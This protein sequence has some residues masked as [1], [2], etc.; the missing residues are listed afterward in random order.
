MIGFEEDLAISGRCLQP[1]GGTGK[2]SMVTLV[3]PACDRMLGGNLGLGL[4]EKCTI[5]SE[6]SMTLVEE[7]WSDC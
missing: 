4:R 1:K 7:L 5:R 2:L 6:P 3:M